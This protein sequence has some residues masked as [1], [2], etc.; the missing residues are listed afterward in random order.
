MVQR[1]RRS[2][3]HPGMEQRNGSKLCPETPNSNKTELMWGP[4]YSNPDPVLDP[5][6]VLDPEPLLDPDL[7]LQPKLSFLAVY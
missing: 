6:L 3:H 1:Q 7:M 4:T 2:L 5:D